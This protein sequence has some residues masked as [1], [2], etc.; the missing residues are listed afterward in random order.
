M[1]ETVAACLDRF[2]PVF[3]RLDRGERPPRAVASDAA[4]GAWADAGIV[5]AAPLDQ[6]VPGLRVRL[7][8]VGD[9]VG[10]KSVRLAKLLGEQ[11]KLAR[12]RLIGNA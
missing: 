6:I 5:V 4:V 10:R 2:K 1:I 9:F 12:S 7:R 11:V 3:G 8:V